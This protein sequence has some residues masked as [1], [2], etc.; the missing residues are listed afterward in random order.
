M[1]F[2]NHHVIMINELGGAAAGDVDYTR[3]RMAMALSRAVKLFSL[4]DTVA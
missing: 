4:I 2:Q 1:A 3:L